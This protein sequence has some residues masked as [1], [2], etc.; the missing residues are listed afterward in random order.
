MSPLQQLSTIIFALLLAFGLLPVQAQTT[1]DSTQQHDETAEPELPKHH[2]RSRMNRLIKHEN[3]P[4]YFDEHTG[5]RE[6]RAEVL[7]HAHNSDS[8]SPHE[9]LHVER[10]HADSIRDTTLHSI[11]DFFKLGTVGGHLRYYG[12]ATTH[13]GELPGHYANAIGAEFRYETARFLGLSMAM[14][15]RFTFGLWR[16]ELSEPDSI[17]GMLPNL[18]RQLFDIEDPENFNDLDRLDELYLHYTRNG[19][20]GK[21]G[22]QYVETPL[23]NK[24]DNRMKSYVTEGLWL[25]FLRENIGRFQGGFLWRFSPRST[26][27]WFESGE[28]VGLYSQGFTVEGEPSDYAHH[29]E[30]PGVVVLGYQSPRW[31]DFKAE[32]WFYAAP[33]LLGTGFLQVEYQ[34]E[35]LYGWMPFGGVQYITQWPIG[36]GGSADPDHRYFDLDERVHIGGAELGY[37]N[38]HW[39]L[40]TRYVYIAESGRFT[41]PREWGR[42]QLFY[43]MSRNRLEG[44]ANTHA[45][46]LRAEYAP[47]A[48]LSLAGEFARRWNPAVDDYRHNKYGVPDMYQIDADIIYEFDDLLKGLSVRFLYIYNFAAE[49]DLTLAQQYYTTNYHHLNLIVQVDW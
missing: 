32:G 33:N 43:H 14:S 38:R 35:D 29:T 40:S 10:V 42:E 4:R 44:L 26:T 5:H 30:T 11:F 37:E 47:S 2:R 36:T 22:R 41:F 28:S 49:D 31:H 25:S 19:F 23:L 39:R 46:Q 24:T 15:G 45:T 18:E 27:E 8:N 3:A 21:L 7:G 17:T 34:P 1:A 48:R 12:M 20:D 6:K 9:A 13:P 16:S